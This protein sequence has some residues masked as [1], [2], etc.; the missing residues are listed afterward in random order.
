MATVYPPWRAPLRGC[1]CVR[2][3][4]GHP[5]ALAAALFGLKRPARNS[6]GQ[7]PR[8]VCAD[9][10]LYVVYLLSPERAPRWG[11]FDASHG[12]WRPYSPLSAPTGR[13]VVAA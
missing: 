8:S 2:G 7:R 12:S 10:S 5:T 9:Q 6:L 13:R 4:H 1:A 3:A 11:A